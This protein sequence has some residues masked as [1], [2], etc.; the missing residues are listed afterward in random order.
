MCMCVLNFIFFQDTSIKQLLNIHLKETE[1][2]TEKV[3]PIQNTKEEIAGFCSLNCIAWKQQPEH[4]YYDHTGLKEAAK[5]AAK[6]I[7]LSF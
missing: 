1:N 7:S 5:Y 6:L 2:H 3:I 4:R